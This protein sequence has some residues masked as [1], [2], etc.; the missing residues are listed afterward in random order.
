MNEKINLIFLGNSDI[1]LS[2]IEVL[3][4]SKY[5]SIKLVVTSADKKM[6]KAK[7]KQQMEVAKFANEKKL[8]L[9]KT[10]N[11]NLEL[12]TLKKY[13]YDYIITC[14][15]GQFLSEKILATANKKAL[16]IHGSLLP[17]GRG[18]APIH[19]AIIEQEKETGYSLMEMIKKMDA[20]NYYIQHK[21][22]I[23]KDETYDSLKQKLIKLIKKNIEKDLI[24][25]NNN[26]LKAIKQEET[27]VNYWLNIKP[28]DEKIDFQKEGEKII[29]QI[30]GLNSQPGSYGMIN[31]LK[32]KIWAGEFLNK[33]I[34]DKKNGE[35]IDL[36]KKGIFIKV[37]DGIILI[38]E[39]TIPGKKKNQI[40][41]IINGKLPFSMGDLF[42]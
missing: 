5:F 11:I 23:D 19:H 21:V 2:V 41:N 35:I 37:K 20:G 4:K 17:K 42:I 12:N 40:K 25:F 30:N 31:N 22:K 18:G 39:I 14:A 27:K 7:K 10:D 24:D 26:K 15:F 9:L 32:I 33:K 8:N 6:G 29:H 36:N 16:N 28:E 3:Y 1:S 34:N 13:D 38:K